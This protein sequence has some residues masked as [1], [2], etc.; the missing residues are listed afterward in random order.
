MLSILVG[1]LLI[2]LLFCFLSML[3]KKFIPS[4]FKFQNMWLSHHD[5]LNVVERNWQA[6]VFPN[7]NISGMVRLWNNLS[8]LK[9]VL[10]W[11]KKHI[12]K[13][14]FANIKNAEN[15]VLELGKAC[16]INLDSSNFVELNVAK[17]NLIT[18]QEQEE[19]Y[20]HQK[21]TTKIMVDGD[22]NT[23]FFHALANKKKIRNHIFKISTDDGRV[24]DEEE[25]IL[26]SGVEHFKNIFNSGFVSSNMIN[27]HIV[28]S[29]ISEADN[30]FLT[31][32]PS[33]DEVWKVMQ[34]MNMDFVAGPDGF[35]TKFFIKTWNITKKDIME[36]VSEFFSG[37][38]H[39]KFFS[40][41][42][43]VLIPNK[44]ATNNWM[45]LDLLVYAPFLIN[46]SLR[47]L[48]LDL[49]IFFPELSL[50]IKLV[51]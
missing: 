17:I 2:M 38:P 23:K 37:K 3:I 36:A 30:L 49:L 35:T 47:S 46:L 11:W 41:T 7:N 50:K 33:D 34:E 27:S 43:I 42:N 28:P 44:E 48:L 21:A 1:I 45:I 25:S 24:L 6:P 13:D 26:N 8:R 5:F 51:L 16:Q 18:L 31:M 19:I 29:C 20:W 22:R 4:A 40:S 39:I 32:S 9:Q 15:E 14:L 10:R 12:F